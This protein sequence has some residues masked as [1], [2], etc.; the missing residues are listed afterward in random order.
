VKTLVKKKRNMTAGWK[1]IGDQLRRIARNHL[2]ARIPWLAMLVLIGNAGRWASA[3]EPGSDPRS[4]QRGEHERVAQETLPPATVD[5]VI[6]EMPSASPV[7]IKASLRQLRGA[8]V[9]PIDLATALA[10]AGVQNPELLIAQTR[11]SESI[12]QHQ[13]AAAQFLP[14]INLGTNYDGHVGALQQ[15]SGNILNL[16]RSALFIGAGANAIAAGTVNIPGVVWNLNVSDAIY[17]TLIAKQLVVQREFESQGVRNE[18]LRQVVHAYLNLLEANG[19][20]SVQMTVRESSAEVARITRAYATTGEGREAD[21]ER[22]VTELFERDA[23]LIT[24]EALANQASAALAEL[25]GLDQSVRYHPTDNFVVPHAIVPSEM[26]LPEALAVALLQRP[27]LKQ[28]QTSV[29]RGLM[30]LDSARLLP[31]S[32]NVFIGYSTGIFGGGS[33]LVAQPNGT[34]TFARGEPAFGSFANR[35]DL[36]VMAYWSLLNLGIGNHALIDA[37][38]ARLRTAQ[39]EEIAVLEQVRKEVA[40]AYRRSQIRL[41]RIRLGAEAMTDADV[42]YHEDLIRTKNN[43]G[44]PIEVLDSLS[45]VERSRMQY[46]RAVM[47]F[48]RA[49]VDLYVALGQPPADML[50]RPVEGKIPVAPPIVEGDESEDADLLK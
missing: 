44:L 36:D 46:L 31:F 37:A 50:A 33:N 32:P 35:Q 40:V 10:L 17:N 29:V 22:A 39:W 43:V 16:Q 1:Q 34:T 18:M 41:R 24:T 21:A 5:D 3:V 12:A 49:Q 38:A 45:L 11:I 42:A 48:N 47:D 27:D 20:R 25:I 23:E 30:A 8:S 28:Q 7:A 9:V 19:K 13:F 26:T 15:S 6:G 4:T 2:D 14:T